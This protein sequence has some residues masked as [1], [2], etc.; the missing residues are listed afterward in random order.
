MLGMARFLR[1]ARGQAPTL[2]VCAL[3]GQLVAVGPAVD[4]G[5]AFLERRRM[6][7]AA[8]AAALAGARRLGP[9]PGFG[10]DACIAH[11]MGVA[12]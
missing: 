12:L 1:P 8:D 2:M 11:T 5:T 7:N 4:R 6:Q 3:V 10:S 9:N